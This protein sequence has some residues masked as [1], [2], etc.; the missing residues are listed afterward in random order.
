[1]MKKLCKKLLA[2]LLC[3]CC[4]PL[5]FACSRDQEQEYIPEGMKIANCVGDD[6]R[7]YVPDLWNVNTGYGVSGAYYKL[8]VQSTVSVV[9]YP[10]DT[11]LPDETAEQFFLRQC[12]ATAEARALGG[13]L[14]L[15]EEDSSAALLDDVNAVRR[16]YSAIMNVYTEEKSEQQELHFVQVVGKRSESFYVFTFSAASALYDSL[17]SDVDKMLSEF[18]FASP[19]TTDDYAKAL[20]EDANAPEGMKLASNS[21]VMYRFYVPKDWV[22]N[23][24]ERIFSAYTAD[25]RSSVSVV[26][27]MPESNSMSVDQYFSLSLDLMQQSGEGQ[28]E[29]ISSGEQVSMG[30]RTATVFDFYY[31]VGGVRY[32]YRQFICAYRSMIYCMTY[33]SLP[34]N[35][36]AHLSDVT[37]IIEAFS[38]R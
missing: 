35:Y 22:V 37:A 25:D 38:F 6:F 10:V 34:E 23:R 16:H 7:L 26:P 15:Y 8:T 1:M 19:Y 12:Y 33:T 31:T 27:Y 11:Q 32:R 36:E 29:L 5:M 13:S 3:I 14:K 21:D 2:M 28:F 17:L 30:G 4:L 9:K 18:I 24:E 20:D